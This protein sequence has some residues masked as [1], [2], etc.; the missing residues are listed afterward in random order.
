MFKFSNSLNVLNIS[1]HPVAQTM[2]MLQ[3]ASKGY[4]VF[5]LCRRHTQPI[6][7]HDGHT[8]MEIFKFGTDCEDIGPFVSASLPIV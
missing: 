8:I 2:W 4:H 1:S 7:T 5:S 6:M 3:F